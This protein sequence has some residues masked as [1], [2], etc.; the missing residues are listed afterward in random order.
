M[1]GCGRA[2]NVST[3]VVQTR[4][5]ENS[6]ES[7]VLSKTGI[8]GRSLSV[9]GVPLS[10]CSVVEYIVRWFAADIACC[11]EKIGRRLLLS[12]LILLAF[13]V[14]QYMPGCRCDKTATDR[15]HGRQQSPR[16]AILMTVL[17]RKFPYL[18]SRGFLLFSSSYR[19][20]TAQK[21]ELRSV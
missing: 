6:P 14:R 10:A 3:V 2:S 16:F 11:R 5:T 12:F 13:V 17:A 7:P 9:A 18:A 4:I 19:K 1:R 8:N 21:E 20:R 15:P